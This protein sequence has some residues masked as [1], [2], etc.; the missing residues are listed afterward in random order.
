M[1]NCRR[2]ACGAW[3]KN[4]KSD[5]P[6]P[7]P[8]RPI[9]TDGGPGSRFQHLPSAWLRESAAG[10]SASQGTRGEQRL[11]KEK[12]SNHSMDSADKPYLVKNEQLNTPPKREGHS[13]KI[14]YRAF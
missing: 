4:R 11:E 2:S 6:P 14:A 12:G 1:L 7:R 3:R 13:I 8:S 10:A 5:T 9:W